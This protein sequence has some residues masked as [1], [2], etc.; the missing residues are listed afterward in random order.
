LKK[1]GMPG[2]L[3]TNISISLFKNSVSG[4]S[5]ER[6]S[7]MRMFL[8]VLGHPLLLWCHQRLLLCVFVSIVRLGHD[9]TPYRV[10]GRTAI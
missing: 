5:D 1:P 6:L 7:F 2:F 4:R 9:R 3:F 8:V 10:K